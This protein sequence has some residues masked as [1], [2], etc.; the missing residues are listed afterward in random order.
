MK[1]NLDARNFRLFG[2]D[3]TASN[4]WGR[5]RGRPTAWLAETQSDDDDH[6]APTAA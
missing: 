1:L 3:E 4:R 6:L 5:S 2:P